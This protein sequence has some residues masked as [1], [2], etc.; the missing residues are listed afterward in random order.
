MISTEEIRKL[1]DNC[2]IPKIQLMENAGRGIHTTLKEKF[3]DLKD[4]R[5]LIVTYHGNNGGDGFVAGRYLCEEA[6]TTILSAG[7]ESKFKEEAR[8]NY[9]RIENNNKIQLFFQTEDIV[10]SDYDIIIDA[11][12]GTGTQGE[13]K[14]PIASVIREVNDSTAFKIA[15]D[16]PSGINPDTGE[17]ADNAINPDLII[18]FHDIKKGLEKFKD[19]TIIVDIGIKETV[20]SNE[21]A[22]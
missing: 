2:G 6:E 14:E 15:V 19:K 4:K 17:T 18:T 1:E 22:T 16:V 8:I 7:D 11:L 20:N 3:P 13:I 12:L 10:F 5:I 21:N 9:I